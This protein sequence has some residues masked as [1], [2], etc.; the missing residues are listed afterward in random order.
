MTLY[1]LL[2]NYFTHQWTNALLAYIR[3]NLWSSLAQAS[4]MAVVLERQQTAL[5]T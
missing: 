2:S 4:I 1:V 5:I 3:S